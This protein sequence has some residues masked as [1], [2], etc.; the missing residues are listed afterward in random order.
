MAKELI[1]KEINSQDMVLSWLFNMGIFDW[2]DPDVRGPEG[3]RSMWYSAVLG[4]RL[5]KLISQ[6]ESKVI[7]FLILSFGEDN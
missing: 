4:H 6:E 2:T 3:I 1:D 5:F 7:A